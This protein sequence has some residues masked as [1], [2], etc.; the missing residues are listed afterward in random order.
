MCDSFKQKRKSFT[1]LLRSNQS[2]T[3]NRNIYFDIYK[4]DQKSLRK[5]V[6]SVIQKSPLLYSFTFQFQLTT[7]NLHMKILKILEIIYKFS[8]SCLSDAISPLFSYMCYLPISQSW[9]SWLSDQLVAVL[10]CLYTIPP[11]LGV[12]YPHR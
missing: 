1:K 5:A 12:S 10:Q 2:K 4:N 3:G 11:P 6:F 7:I 8:I 9:T